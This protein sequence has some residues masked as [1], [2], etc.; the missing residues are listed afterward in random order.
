MTFEKPGPATEITAPTPSRSNRFCGHGGTAR[1]ASR[2]FAH[3]KHF[4][5]AARPQHETVCVEGCDRF[6]EAAIRMVTRRL[7]R[8]AQNQ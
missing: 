7:S 8:T 4:V 5:F 3:R 2:P 1:F 6:V